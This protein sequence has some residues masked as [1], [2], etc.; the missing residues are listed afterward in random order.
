MQTLWS[1]I[2]A[3]EANKPGSFSRKTVDLTATLDKSDAHLFT[4]FC[5]FVWASEQLIPIIKNEEDLLFKNLGINFSSLTHL[6]ALGLIT[7]RSL[8]GF[9]RQGFGKRTSINY[10]G[11]RIIIEFPEE[12]ND[13]DIGKAMLTRAGQQL[14]PLCGSTRW[15]CCTNGVMARLPLYPGRPIPRFL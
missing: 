14:A 9:I 7:F 6:K 10:Y 13:L 3:G 4:K 12:K 8:S 15:L 1:N 11:S 5:T 2:L